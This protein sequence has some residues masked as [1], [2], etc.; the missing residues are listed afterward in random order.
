LGDGGVGGEEWSQM[1]VLAMEDGRS[2][3]D[4]SVHDGG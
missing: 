2:R 3:I 1:M 4:G